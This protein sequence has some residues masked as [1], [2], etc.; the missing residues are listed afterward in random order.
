MNRSSILERLYELKDYLEK[1]S[2]LESSSRD[3][4][5]LI[6]DFLSNKVSISDVEVKLRSMDPSYIR[7]EFLHNLEGKPVYQ[8]IKD[9]KKGKLTQIQIAKM[10]SSLI[11]QVLIQCERDP[12]INCK[13]LQIGGLMKVLEEYSHNSEIINTELLDYLLASYGWIDE[14]N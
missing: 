12:S 13:S 14:D 3:V 4:D 2:E 9:Y 11:T 1:D 10:V 5:L 8:S 7:S 6:E